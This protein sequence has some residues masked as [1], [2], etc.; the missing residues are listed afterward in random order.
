VWIERARAAWPRSVWLNPVAEQSW[1]W[2]TSTGMMK[3]LFE[4]RMYPVTLA[5]LES[6]M[7]SLS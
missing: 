1:G 6:A 4:G 7:R 3:R 2:S 5:G